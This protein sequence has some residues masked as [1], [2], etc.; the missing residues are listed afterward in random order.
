MITVFRRGFNIH[1]SKVL[2]SSKP[3]ENFDNMIRRSAEIKDAEQ[4]M[5]SQNQIILEIENKKIK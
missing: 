2:F 3:I 1:F 4:S 5:K